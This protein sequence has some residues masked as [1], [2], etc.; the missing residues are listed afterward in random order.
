MPAVSLFP[1]FSSVVLLLPFPDFSLS[2]YFSFYLSYSSLL[3]YYRLSVCLS[4]TLATPLFLSDFASLFLGV[5]M[6]LPVVGHLQ[7]IETSSSLLPLLPL[8]RLISA[9]AMC[10]PWRVC[11]VT[12]TVSVHIV[13]VCVSFAC[14]CLFVSCTHRCLH[15][16]S[17]VFL[18]GSQW[19][20]VHVW[21]AWR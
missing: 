18:Q 10:V 2:L 21:E 3:T 11:C 16:M 7:N 8:N 19:L 15:L 12:V 6:R 14:I 13:G 17:Y 4:L 5:L 9:Y 20:C 1:A